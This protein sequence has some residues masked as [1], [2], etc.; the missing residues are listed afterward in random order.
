M[1]IVLL[2]EEEEAL[3]K[4]MWGIQR[5]DEEEDIKSG[6]ERWFFQICVF[7]PCF[8]VR[9]CSEHGCFLVRK[10][11]VDVLRRRYNPK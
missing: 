4:F 5:E 2:I 10:G 3:I 8:P 7:C 6:V 1:R 11:D 9:D